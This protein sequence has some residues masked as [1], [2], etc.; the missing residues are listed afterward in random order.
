MPDELDA[1]GIVREYIELLPPGSYR[2]QPLPRSPAAIPALTDSHANWS[3]DS[4]TG[5]VRVGFAPGNRSP[6]TSM[7]WS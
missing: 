2:D 1:A 5:W 4:S 3:I 6:P 7:G